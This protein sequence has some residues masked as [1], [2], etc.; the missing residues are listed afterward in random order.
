MIHP[1]EEFEHLKGEVEAEVHE[2]GEKL[3]S[4]KAESLYFRPLFDA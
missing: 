4:S 2:E 3:L 1:E